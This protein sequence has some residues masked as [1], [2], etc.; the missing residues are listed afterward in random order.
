MRRYYFIPLAPAVVGL[1]LALIAYTAPLGNTGVNGSTGALL[2]LLGALATVAGIVI[3]MMPSVKHRV[4]GSLNI[5][6]LLGAGLTAVAAYFLMQYAFATT[7]VATCL[8]VIIAIAV[9][10]RRRPA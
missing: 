7:M 5:L 6:V 9:S 3:V 2:A 8:A 1:M 4:W 10:L